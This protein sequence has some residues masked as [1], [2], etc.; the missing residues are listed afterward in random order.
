MPRKG[1]LWSW[2]IQRFRPKTPPYAGPEE[3]IPFALGYVEL[4]GVVI[5]ETRL[6]QADFDK[7]KIGMEMEVV[8]EPLTT[9]SK[10]RR[11]MTYAFRPTGEEASDE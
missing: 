10:G 9:D 4:P 2:T 7:L 3:F 1:H 5:V 6:V 8:L 11:I